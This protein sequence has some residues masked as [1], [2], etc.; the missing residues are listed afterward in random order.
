MTMAEKIIASHLVGDGP[1][2]REARRRR[3]WPRSTAATATSSPPPRCT[4]SCAR[5]S[6]PTTRSRTRASSPSSRTTSSTPTTSPRMAR[7]LARDPDPARPAAR[8]PEAHRRA[9]LQRAGRRLSPGI[10]HQVAREADHRARRLHPGDGQPHLHGRRRQRAGLRRRR[11]G[12]RGARAERAS[13]SWRCPRSIRFELVGR[14]AARRDRQGRDAAH[15]PA[16][17]PAAEDAR[18]H[19]GVRRRGPARARRWTSARRWPTWPPSA[20]RARASARPTTRRR[21]GSPRRRPGADLDALRARF[22][23]P[24]AG[25]GLRRRRAHASTCGAIEPMVADP[26]DPD[27]GIPSDPTNGRLVRELGDVRHRHRLRRLVHRRQGGRLRH[28]RR[29]HAGG[30]RERPARGATGVRFFIQFGSRGGRALRGRAG[31]P[32]GLRAR[33][34]WS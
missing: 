20:A 30:R 2:L 33:P 29:R 14:A 9:R 7:F 18:P 3:A 27:R 17:R 21:A 19:H 34:A 24:D 16:L 13:P 32:R 8:V 31:L 6:A 1:A 15:P 12:V 26:G 10:C 25:R 11:H 5:S 23:A 28:V 22:V 4:S